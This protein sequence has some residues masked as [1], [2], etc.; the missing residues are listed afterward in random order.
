M[1]FGRDYKNKRRIRIVPLDDAGEAVEY[2]IPKGKHLPV[3]EGD[4]IEKG[5]YIMDGNRRRTTSW[6]SRAWR[7]SPPTSSTRSRRSTGCRA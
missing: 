4:F 7:S 1:E 6:R 5:E 3:Q 2:L